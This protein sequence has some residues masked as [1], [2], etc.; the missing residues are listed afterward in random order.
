M[1]KYSLNGCVMAG[2]A[3][4]DLANPI[5][6]QRFPGHRGSCCK[7]LPGKHLESLML[8]TLL[9]TNCWTSDTCCSP[10]EQVTSY[11]PKSNPF[12]PIFLPSRLSPIGLAAGG[13]ARKP[14]SQEHTDTGALLPDRPHGDT[15][16]SECKSQG[17]DKEDVQQEP[18]A[19][20][21]QVC[22]FF[23]PSSTRKLSD[24]R[25]CRH[26]TVSYVFRAMPF[27]CHLSPWRAHGTTWRAQQDSGPAA[28]YC[29][30][31]LLLITA[32]RLQRSS[33]VQTQLISA[34]CKLKIK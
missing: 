19:L 5:K 15:S 31:L 20:S 30:A 29:H 3:A 27:P 8:E 10:A 6:P 28:S 14:P 18:T 12:S 32:L 7:P 21:P 17:G 4:Q 34:Q 11:V 24:F 1:E 22:G 16:C 33:R 25:Q 13:R 9:K 23:L 26:R 2:I